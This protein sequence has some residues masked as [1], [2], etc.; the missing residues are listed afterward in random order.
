MRKPRP[1]PDSREHGGRFRKRTPRK[2]TRASADQVAARDD[3]PAQAGV[4][5]NALTGLLG[6]L[7]R[8]ADVR[9]ALGEIL[10]HLLSAMGLDAGW[11]VLREPAAR[12]P[13]A[14][15]GFVLA[16]H[17]GLPPELGLEH[18]SIWDMRCSCEARC[19]QGD[20]TCA[21][22]EVTCPRLEAIRKPGE[23]VAAHASAPLRT[24]GD[25]LKSRHFNHA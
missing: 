8:A 4:D 11:I 6:A 25:V 13:G 24:N 7:N 9:A 1:P 22:N 19:T 20:A 15:P 2:P 23:P 21:R 3:A 14:G 12:E 18:R 5:P 10:E 16:A 17:R